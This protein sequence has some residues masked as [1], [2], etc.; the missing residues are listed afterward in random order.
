MVSP[1]TLLLEDQAAGAIRATLAQGAALAVVSGSGLGVLR[2]LGREIAALPFSAIPGLGAGRVA[3][4][5]GL[6]SLL[7]TD[8]GRLYCLTGRRHLYEGLDPAATG[9]AMRVLARLG[10]GRVIL[11]NAAGALSPRLSVGDLMLIRD[12]LNMMFC[13][14]LSGRGEPGAQRDRVQNAPLSERVEREEIYDPAMNERLR[15]AALAEA[16]A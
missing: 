8:A 13:N 2:T 4:H 7:E 9:F 15:E 12:H 16:I 11:T 3:G 10:V 1:S 14:P 6:W 5:A